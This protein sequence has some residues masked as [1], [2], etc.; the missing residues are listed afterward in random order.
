MNFCEI[1][2]TFARNNAHST[3]L[4]FIENRGTVKDLL[5]RVKKKVGR[6]CEILKSLREELSGECRIFVD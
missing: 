1:I 6:V 4:R 3:R 2:L 5:D